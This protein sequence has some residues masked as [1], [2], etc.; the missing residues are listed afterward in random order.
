MLETDDHAWEVHDGH[1][2][3]RLTLCRKPI[4]PVVACCKTMAYDEA[5]ELWWAD[6]EAD[7]VRN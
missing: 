4:R 7:Y 2:D 6:E 5:V 3:S 1:S